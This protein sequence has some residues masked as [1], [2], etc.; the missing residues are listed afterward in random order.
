MRNGV[1]LCNKSLVL[2]FLAWAAL[3]SSAPAQPDYHYY[4]FKQR[5]SVQLDLARIAVE[6][7][8]NPFDPESIRSTVE[9]NGATLIEVRPLGI[10]SWYFIQIEPT[11]PAIVEAVIEALTHVPAVAFA[12]P[13]FLGQR[14]GWFVPTQNVLAQV[15]GASEGIDII[16][17]TNS[18]GFQ[19]EP[20]DP[21]EGGFILTSQG[22]S[23]LSVLQAANDLAL[24]PQVQFA[25][26]DMIFSGGALF[27]PNDSGFGNCWGIQNTGQFGGIED[28]DMD[29][30]E[31]WDTTAGDPGIIVVVIDSGVQQDHPD[32]HQ[33]PGTDV[34]S[35]EG[36]GGGPVNQFDRH[37]T[38]VAGSISGIMNN[39]IGTV[40]IAPGCVTASARTFI[41]VDD[42]GKWVS[43]SSWTVEAL[44]WA[45]A[46]GARV[47]NN[48]NFYGFESSAI[49]Q[50][51]EE[52][53]AAGLVHFAS[54][55][56]RGSAVVEYPAI[57]PSV[58]SAGA[59]QNDG[60]LANFSSFGPNLDL[61]APGV[62]IYT[63]DRTGPDG[64]I[65][66]SYVSLS[67]SSFSSSYSAGVAALYLSTHPTATASTVEEA[68]KF[69]ADDLG[70]PG[71]DDTF[72]WGLVNSANAIS[73]DPGCDQIPTPLAE[74]SGF[75]K[76]RYL[77]LRPGT[78]GRIAAIAVTVESTPPAGQQI[79]GNTYWVGEPVA[80][81]PVPAPG[82]VFP[83]A[84]LT[85]QPTFR[86]WSD[87]DV[88]HVYGAA[89]MPSSNYLLQNVYEAC[90][91]SA[92]AVASLPLELT[93][94]RWA[95][96]APLFNPPSETT[97]PDF[98][99]VSA[100]VDRFRASPN[101]PDFTYA[102][103]D[104]QVPNQDVNFTDVSRVVDA[105]RG[106]PYPWPPPSP[107]P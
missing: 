24:D 106:I 34:T 48:S 76:S 66:G 37:G 7:A 51:Y 87:V 2:I 99:D 36:N 21:I 27:I 58:V 61:V 77:S 68:L 46:I 55:G 5:R 56:N 14:G 97:Q 1:V 67:G 73:W 41:A 52:T 86:D 88:L 18:H 72:G 44:Q 38:V 10:G 50:K 16:G 85:C 71:R 100:A 92:T 93:T 60:M 43:E 39:M 57:L 82:T 62:D 47:S 15:V 101:S 31:A 70:A 13:V 23:G 3:V 33:I 6:S 81:V 103:L 83:I 26:P 19:S 28:V 9:E 8:E 104:P 98:I 59:I 105:F 11:Q 78:A 89:V 63:T 69:S 80:F 53:R 17:I 74:P 25:E 42:Q 64:Y 40:G 84:S 20:W 79:V 54:A 91:D 30:P 4:Y 45:E 32:I 12:S 65:I 95:D 94:A 49:T 90:Q 75:P 96:L 35:E 22:L 107:C 102:D 29:G